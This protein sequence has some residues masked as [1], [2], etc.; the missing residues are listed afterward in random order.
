LA[1]SARLA[2]AQPHPWSASLNEAWFKHQ[3]A[4]VD[5]GQLH[6]CPLV[7]RVPAPDLVMDRIPILLDQLG[8]ARLRGIPVA[9]IG[10]DLVVAVSR[11]EIALQIH[12]P[13]RYPSDGESYRK[14]LERWHRYP[15]TD[16]ARSERW[17][18]RRDH[19]VHLLSVGCPPQAI[20]EWFFE[21]PAYLNTLIAQ[22][23]TVQNGT[24]S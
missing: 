12:R 21:T 13:P 15:L 19:A 10:G 7:L 1:I 20:A 5:A 2:C 17:Q 9:R 3:V 22:A 11:F 23:P 4:S 16:R 8:H 24:Q 18:W 14:D 6:R